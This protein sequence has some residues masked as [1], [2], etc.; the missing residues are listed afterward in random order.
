MP[1]ALPL[2]LDHFPWKV[3][4]E[5]YP[6]AAVRSRPLHADHP[7]VLL[8][9]GHDPVEK[10][11]GDGVDILDPVDPVADGPDSLPSTAA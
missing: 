1:S 4:R 3:V 5:L 6:T 11:G 9:P 7:Q 2:R 10:V 8:E